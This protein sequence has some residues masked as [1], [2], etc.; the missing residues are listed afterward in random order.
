[1]K[2]D[3]HLSPIQQFWLGAVALLA[4]IL[5]SKE[6]GDL[7][8]EKAVPAT[9]TALYLMGNAHQ[10]TSQ[11][12]QQKLVLKMKP[13]LRFMAADNKNFTAAYPMLLGEEFSKQATT[14]VEQIK[15]MKKLTI[16]TK[17]KRFSGY[18]SKVIKAATMIDPR[19]AMRDTICTVKARQVNHPTTQVKPAKNKGTIITKCC[20][21]SQRNYKVSPYFEFKHSTTLNNKEH[22]FI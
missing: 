21:L 18:H 13:F 19:V 1:M 20:K 11:E 9:Q 12:R 14:T 2:A 22:G 7:I 17:K 3:R 5:E 10:H 16:P 4:A 6:A 8:P 15:A